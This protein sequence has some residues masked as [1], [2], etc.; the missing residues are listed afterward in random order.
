MYSTEDNE[1]LSITESD[2]RANESEPW[3]MRLETSA[4]LREA[5]VVSTVKNRIDF[6]R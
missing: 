3:I 5:F 2:S 4:G 6:V 1:H